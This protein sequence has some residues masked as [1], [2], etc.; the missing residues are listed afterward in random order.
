[1]THF[2]HKEM[3]SK[4]PEPIFP[5]YVLMHI[6]YVSWKCSFLS[7]SCRKIYNS[8]TQFR[9]L[10]SFYDPSDKNISNLWKEQKILICSF[11]ALAKTKW[12]D[13][14]IC[15]TILSHNQ[16]WWY[17]YSFIWFFMI[18]YFHIALIDQMNS[19]NNT[20]ANYVYPIHLINR[21][22]ILS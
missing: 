2:F 10:F 4:F 13:L 11:P 5:S 15:P 6:K 7:I 19:R 22:S 17:G 12:I 14:L 20:K 18:E 16:N 1:M 3:Y 8:S 9:I 21:I